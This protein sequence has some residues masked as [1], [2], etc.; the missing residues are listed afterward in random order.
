MTTVVET[1][2][3]AHSRMFPDVLQFNCNRSPLHTDTIPEGDTITAPVFQ[4]E[5]NI[6]IFIYVTAQYLLLVYC[7]TIVKSESM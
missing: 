3:K 1:G 5:Y 7:T 6:M 2:T 4:P